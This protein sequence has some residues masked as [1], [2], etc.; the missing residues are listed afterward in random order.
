M[1]MLDWAPS[2]ASFLTPQLNNFQEGSISWADQIA[3][4]EY[5]HVQQFNNFNNGLSKTM[6]VL[7]G[8]EGYALAIN[9]SIPDWFYEG[10]AVYN[11]TVLTKQ[12]RGGYPFFL[13]LS[14]QFGRPIRNIHG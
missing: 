12:G 13:T 14:L 2:E 9:A 8:E 11:E 1:D 6:K 5:R 10:D 4:H 7:F 3:V